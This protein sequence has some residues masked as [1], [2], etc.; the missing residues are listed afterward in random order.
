MPLSDRSITWI[1]RI[2]SAAFWT[3]IG[4]RM[5]ASR[6]GNASADDDAPSPTVHDRRTATPTPTA[7]ASIS[8]PQW[9]LIFWSSCAAMAANSLLL[10]LW[11]KRPQQLGPAV[12][13]TSAPVQRLGIGLMASGIGLMAWAYL[14]FR[15]F[16]LLPKIDEGHQLCE[17]GP[18]ALLRHPIYGG[19]NLFYLGTLCLAPRLG[20]LLQ[21]FASTIAFDVRARAEEQLLVRAFGTS[22][23]RY[24]E[25]TRRFIP[26]LY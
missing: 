23:T 13:P 21:L 5:A 26:G 15:S 25:R 11:S 22:Y 8:A 7:D 19:I 24:M 4:A 17:D 20:L 16:R 18:F 10:L 14:V 6:W 12:L 2:G 3:L 1:L 9:Q